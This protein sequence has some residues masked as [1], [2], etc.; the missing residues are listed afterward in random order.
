[1]V[2]NI[3]EIN[4]FLDLGCNAVEA[5]VKFIDAYPKNAFHGQPC[6][7]DRYC[8]SSED[9]AKYLNYVRKITTPEIAASGEVGHR[10]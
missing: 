3:T 1:M 6:D 7:C 2:N 9:L 4:Q 8:D 5:D 10:K